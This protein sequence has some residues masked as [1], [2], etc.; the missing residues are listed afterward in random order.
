MKK[1]SKLQESKILKESLSY[2]INGD[3]SKLSGYLLEEQY[4]FCAY[5]ETFFGRTDKKEIDHFNPNLK[6]KLED[7]YHNWFL[8]K[9]QWNAE[10]STK[11]DNYQ[12][13]LHPT[14]HDFETR[15]IYFEGDYFVADSQD[16]EAYN[17]VQLLKLDNIELA[18][19]RKQYIARKRSEIK[20]YGL[21]HSYFENLLNEDLNA[22]RFIRAIQE[23]FNIDIL[24]LLKK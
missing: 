23:E 11:W 20:A 14:A 18:F 22:I 15:I 17:L 13:I 10:K 21:A 19:E 3:N 2:R 6:G 8:I 1:V 4:G 24:L 5:T 16:I 12:P 9:A 7:N